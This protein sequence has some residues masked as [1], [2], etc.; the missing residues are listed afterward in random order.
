MVNRLWNATGRIVSTHLVSDPKNGEEL[1]TPQKS[2]FG[3]WWKI[4]RFFLGKNDQ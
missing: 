1:T 3:I 2:S 4:T